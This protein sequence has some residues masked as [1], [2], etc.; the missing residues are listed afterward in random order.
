MDNVS[1]GLAGLLLAGLGTIGGAFKYFNAQLIGARKEADDQ[2]EKFTDAETRARLALA[3]AATSSI[4]ELRRDFE[5]SR[6]LTVRREEMNA[7][8]SRLVARTDKIDIK[9]DVMVERLATLSTLDPQ[10]KGISERL[11]RMLARTDWRL[12]RSAD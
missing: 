8:E 11:D 4:T 12:T 7:M 1:I 5:T 2:M 6:T 9:I 10:V 3:T